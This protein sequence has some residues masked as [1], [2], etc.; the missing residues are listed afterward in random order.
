MPESR[1]R[2]GGARHHQTRGGALPEWR[3]EHPSY[4]LV[5]AVSASSARSLIGYRVPES[6]TCPDT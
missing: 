1:W 5:R 4:R 3:V 6:W 2:L